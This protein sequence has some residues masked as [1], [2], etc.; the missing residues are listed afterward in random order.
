MRRLRMARPEG[1]KLEIARRAAGLF[2]PFRWHLVALVALIVIT[3]VLNL[4]PVLLIRE[5]VNE[6]D[7]GTAGSG[8]RIGMLA[9]AMVVMYVTSG[10]L[11]VA[12]GY[13]NQHVGQGVMYNVRLAL[14]THLQRLSVRFFTATRTGEILSRITTDVNAMQQAVTGT[15]TEFLRNLVT[16]GVAAGLMFA[17]D[18]RLALIVMI[19]LPLWVYPTVRV[20]LHQ[21]RLQLEWHEESSKLS[22]NLEETLSVSGSMLVKTFGREKYE[23]ER[24]EESNARLR[25]LSIRRLIAGRWFNMASSLFGLLS[26][27]VIYWIGGISVTNGS[28]TV[29]DIIAFAALATQVFGPFQMIARIN[30]TILSSL[31]LFERIF[32]YLDLPVEVDEAPDAQRLESPVG[33]LEF[34]DVRFRYTDRGA[35]ALDGV[36][37]EVAPGQMVALVGPSGAGKTTMTYLMQ[38][39]Y[40]PQEGSVRIDGHDLRELTLDSMSRAIG[41]VMQETYLFHTSLRDNIRYGRL[42][43]EDAEVESAASAAGLGDLVERLPDGLDTVVGERGYRLSGGEKQRVAIARAV[44]NDPP[45]L[46][47]DEATS[48]LDTKLEREIRE[49]TE[50]LARGRTTIVIAHRLSTVIAADI[51]LVLEHGHVVERGRHEEL[52]ALGGLYASL[53]R[54]QF[55]AEERLDAAKLPETAA[56]GGD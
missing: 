51:I 21:R 17:L 46:I 9:L 32:E 55:S 15:F 48:S 38:R 3:V 35:P 36:S 8:S 2:A 4:A 23:A 5:I 56:G 31:A 39:Y 16:L 11:G 24:F 20:G 26:V 25:Q 34:R 54:E 13:L 33:R 41:T 27:A 19:V 37:F 45:I 52:L 22:A 18:W 29:G 7:Q 53:Y 12:E 6:M 30:T 43:A 49:A 1:S 47:L 42:D 44:L 14:H 28:V 50:E 40:D 10:L